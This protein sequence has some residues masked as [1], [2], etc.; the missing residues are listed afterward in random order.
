[1]NRGS[2]VRVSLVLALVALA[3]T[4]PAWLP[5]YYLQLSTRSL[6]LA[7]TAMSFILVA[8]YGG[9]VSLAQMSFFAAAGYITGICVMT[10]GWSHALAIPAALVGTV[11]LS[12]AFAGLAIRAK[13]IYFLMM[14]LALSQLSYGVTLHW[15]EV[16]R[17]WEGFSGITRPVIFG[18]SLIEP[19][20]MFYV[21]LVI[22]TASYLILH[23]VVQSP[24]GLALQGIRDNPVKMRALGYDV[25]LHRFVA[26]VVSGFFAGVAGVLGV[27]YYGGVSPTTTG[28][29]QILLVVMAA[30]VGGT[31]LLEGGIVGSFVTVLLM[32]FASQFTQRYMSIIGLVFVL[33]IILL[34]QGML[35]SKRQLTGAYSR[36]RALFEGGM[37][38]ATAWIARRGDGTSGAIDKAKKLSLP[39]RDGMT[40]D[41]ALGCAARSAHREERAEGTYHVT[42]SGSAEE[43]AQN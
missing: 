33:V 27:F 37:S 38:A 14:T 30:I 39:A 7:I 23:R 9:M 31:S 20:P 36:T 26:L 21:T 16:T 13:G 34:P 2:W 41:S 43:S 25:Q 11:L 4:A 6:I 24:F 29:S 35:G 1:M 5:G 42:G 8:G 3:A 12:A 22:A 32:S 15:V 18:R 28:L 17:G 40:G 10:H 19:V